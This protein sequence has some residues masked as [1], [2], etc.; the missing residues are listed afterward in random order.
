VERKILKTYLTPDEIKI[1]EEKVDNLRDRLL[2][3]LLFHLGCRVN[4]A[5]AL[6]VGHIDLNNGLV[7]IQH[8]KTRARLNCPHCS[9]R[10]SRSSIYCSTCGVKVEKVVA[11]AVENRK[12]RT[13]PIDKE[14]LNLVREYIR[15]GGPVRKNNKKLIFGINR[16]RAWQIVRECA[17]KA[18]LPELFNPETGRA[19]RVSP[20]RLRDAFAVHAVKLNDSGLLLEACQHGV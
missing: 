1:M 4:E 6:E 16:H 15:R 10:L 5:L 18:G 20:H 2:V 19:H 11:K 12:M 13:L 7:I 3:R 14:T 17:E 9:S 8:L